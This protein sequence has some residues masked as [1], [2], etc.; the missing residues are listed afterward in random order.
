ML[1]H[2]LPLVPEIDS[3]GKYADAVPLYEQSLAIEEKVLDPEAESVARSLNNQ[4]QLLTA[5]VSSK[6]YFPAVF[7]LDWGCLYDG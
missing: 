4:A 6:R 2:P 5:Q 7:V 1:T 3:Q